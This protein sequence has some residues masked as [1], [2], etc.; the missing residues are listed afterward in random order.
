MKEHDKNIEYEN[1][2]T[3]WINEKLIKQ[4]SNFND[5]PKWMLDLR[6]QAFKVFKTKK[7]PNWGP[8]LELLNLDEI[9]Y[10]AKP[11]EAKD[12]S[13]WEE[14]P[15]KLKKTFDKLWIPEA[16][17]K[18]LSWVWA[19]YDSS[20]V[21]HSIDNELIKKWVVFMDINSA[22][23]NKK[24]E[25][26][27]KK[28]FSKSI[29]INNHKF[30]SLHYS[31]W[32]WWTFL[33]VPEWVKIKEPLQSYFRMNLESWWQFEHTIIILESEAEAH[34]I[35]WCSAPKYNKNSLHAWW[36]EIFLAK[37]AKMRYSSV[38]NW[39]TD[40]YNLNTKRAIIEEGWHIDWV[41][42]NMWSGLTML[43]PC[44][45]LKWDNS[46]ANHLW[47]A[48]A[49][50]WQNQDT[51]AKVIH[52]WKNTSSKIISKSLSKWNWICTF[53]WL[54]EVKK[55][56]ENS[57]V[58]SDCDWL[59]IDEYSINN[60]IPTIKVFNTSSSVVHEASS[61]RINEKFLYYLMSRWI[62]KEEAL[63][64]IVNWFLSSITNELPL[65][66]ASEMNV[67]ISMEFEWWF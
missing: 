10:F 28:Y 57:L 40:T 19:Q 12:Y 59:I 8:N 9:Y 21:Y 5:E 3:K 46:S 15:E 50:D 4:I 24:Y 51:W 2:I 52:I 55:S 31:V 64:I 39:S 13:S 32:S 60:A 49:N 66:Y 35:E 53:R 20:V 62:A 44:S 43:Y 1:V 16:E 45:V 26:L 11:K 56:A 23:K 54:I 58:Q 29:S 18:Y 36:V 65:E 67:L 63:W 14:V 17:K 48:I 7:M 38:E 61:G 22:L 47:L 27:I 34:Y 33:Y 41:W 6:L 42:W 25:K 30:A 37:D